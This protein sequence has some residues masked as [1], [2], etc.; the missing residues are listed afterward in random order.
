MPLKN[1]QRVIDE[2]P[3][4]V[5]E[6]VVKWMDDLDQFTESELFQ[7]T[8][9]RMRNAGLKDKVS[10]MGVITLEGFLHVATFPSSADI[11]LVPGYDEGFGPVAYDEAHNIVREQ[12]LRK[13]FVEYASFA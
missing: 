1:F 8:L 11:E 3:P 4:K 9:S 10:T 5:K 6:K 13:Y 12:N 7:Q 2:T